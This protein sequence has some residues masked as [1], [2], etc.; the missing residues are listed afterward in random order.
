[1]KRLAPVITLTIL[2]FVINIGC[3]IKAIGGKKDRYTNK[4]SSVIGFHITSEKITGNVPTE[5][6]MKLNLKAGK[7]TVEEVR[8]WFGEPFQQTVDKLKDKTIFLYLYLDETDDVKNPLQHKEAI[9]TFEK[10]VVA[11]FGYFDVDAR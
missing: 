11:T 8:G 9:I 3:T 2:A 10:G 6:T 4:I 1:M 5:E 7:T